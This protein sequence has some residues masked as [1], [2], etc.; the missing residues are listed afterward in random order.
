MRKK[1]R[2]KRS[3]AN[4]RAYSPCFGGKCSLFLRFNS[5]TGCFELWKSVNGSVLKSYSDSK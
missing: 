3:I 2:K 5:N 1:R 4:A